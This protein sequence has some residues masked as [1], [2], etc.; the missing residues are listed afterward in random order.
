MSDLNTYLRPYE[1]ILWSGKPDKVLFAFKAPDFAFFFVFVLSIPVSLVLTSHFHL[2]SFPI[3]A[4]PLFVLIAFTFSFSLRLIDYLGTEYIITD[5]R[6]IVR[7]GL[8]LASHRQGEFIG[9]VTSGSFI[10][11]IEFT[12]VIAVKVRGR[13]IYVGQHHDK[14][15]HGLP[16]EVGV[17]D[18]F[19]GSMVPVF[20]SPSEPQKVA[21]Q[22]T[23]VWNDSARRNQSLRPNL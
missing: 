14:N 17:D 16:R 9:T 20:E 21:G 12:D 18:G 6:V 3:P 7:K 5:Q 23:D 4:I 2:N 15:S 22:L 13:R 19:G 1:R 10:A 8:G 11:S